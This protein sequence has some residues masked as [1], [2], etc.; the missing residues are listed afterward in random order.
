MR[1][2]RARVQ[3]GAV[4]ARWL[5]L[6]RDFTGLHS[7]STKFDGLVKPALTL[8]STGALC[9]LCL[10]AHRIAVICGCSR[11]SRRF[12]GT[13]LDA[14]I[15]PMPAVPLETHPSE[16]RWRAPDGGAR[17][18]PLRPAAVVRRR[19]CSCAPP[20][21]ARPLPRTKAIS[22]PGR[23][24]TRSRDAAGIGAEPRPSSARRR[25]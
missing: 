16:E 19:R 2:E 11:Y 22:I 8:A 3:L 15:L 23:R 24:R 12:T 20:A 17:V 25:A 10:R 14:P 18:Q 6:D 4:L 21:A 5:T 9:P 1:R 13:V 7:A